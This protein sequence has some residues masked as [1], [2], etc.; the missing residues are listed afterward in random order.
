M[1]FYVWAEKMFLLIV[2]LGNYSMAQF[3]KG[4][5]FFIPVIIRPV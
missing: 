1:E 5:A 3:Q 2:S 4:F